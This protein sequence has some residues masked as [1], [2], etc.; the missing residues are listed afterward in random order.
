[1][2]AAPSSP[3]CHH[4][5]LL[6]ACAATPRKPVSEPNPVRV[7]LAVMPGVSMDIHPYLDR[8]H[9]AKPAHAQHPSQHPG[10][11]SIPVRVELAV[12]CREF[13][14][15]YTLNSTETTTP[16][17]PFLTHHTSR[18]AAAPVFESSSL[19]T[20]RVHRPRVPYTHRAASLSLVSVRFPVPARHDLFTINRPPPQ[21]AR[22]RT[23]VSC[24]L[25]L[26]PSWWCTW[27]PA[28]LCCVVS[29]V[30]S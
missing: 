1:V 30:H 8:D 25:V 22:A 13:P 26:Q 10:H 5:S 20:R 29:H 3:P 6:F 16:N 28:V 19:T 4:P 15:T 21:R 11:D 7:E 18:A 17:P 9:H 14:W 2:H 12:M 24:E 27:P 23:A